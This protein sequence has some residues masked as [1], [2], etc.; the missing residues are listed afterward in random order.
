M[1]KEI[2][3]CGATFEISLPYSP[4]EVTAA[5]NW[6]REHHHESQTVAPEVPK[7][8]SEFPPTPPQEEFPTIP[9]VTNEEIMEAMGWKDIPTTFVK[10]RN[11]YEEGTHW[12][13][14]EDGRV[15]IHPHRQQPD[16]FA[17]WDKRWPKP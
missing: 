15:W 12:V 8:S 9:S 2:C 4:H 6:R 16:D 11:W 5:S 3:S 10:G 14:G 17:R 13:W 1:I 7:V